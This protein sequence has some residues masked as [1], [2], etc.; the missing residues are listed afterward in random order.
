MIIR[1]IWIIA[2]LGLSFLL[3]DS[4]LMAQTQSRQNEQ[5]VGCLEFNQANKTQQKKHYFESLLNDSPFQTQFSGLQSKSFYKS[6]KIVLI[7]GDEEYRSEEMLTQWAKILAF[8]H[9]FDCVVLY[10]INKETGFIDPLTQNNIPGLNE[11]RNADLMVIFTRFRDLPD[12]QMKEIDDYL[13]SGRPV[14]GIRTATHAFAIPQNRPFSH[15]SFDYQNSD[16]KSNSDENSDWTQGFGR[17]ILG[18]TWISHHGNHGVE[19]TRGIISSEEANHP[20]LKGVS[21]IFGLTDVYSVRLPLPDGCRPLVFGQVLQGMSPKDKPVQNEKNNPMIP[22]V[23]VKKYSVNIN[24]GN[25]ELFDLQ[26]NQKSMTQNV[27][28]VKKV[29]ST[30]QNDDL[31]QGNHKVFVSTMGSGE[32]FQNEG[33]RRLLVNAVYWLNDLEDQI[34]EAATVEFLEQYEPNSMGFGQFKKNVKPTDW[35]TIH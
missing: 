35:Q 18:E 13:Q 11:L 25:K 34:P 22:V 26:N 28:S 29:D 2:V 32:D 1:R 23:W 9:G 33:Y 27:I 10:S 14:L 5:S 4:L 8:H 21:D 3:N 30:D 16:E 20:I 19:A 6:K 24:I 7:S 12:D 15:Y 31:L 17:K